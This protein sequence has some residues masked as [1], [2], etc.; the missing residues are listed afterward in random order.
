MS[1]MGDDYELTSLLKRASIMG[2]SDY[3]SIMPMTFKET[4]EAIKKLK[5]QGN[6]FTTIDREKI[7]KFAQKYFAGEDYLQQKREK[8]VHSFWTLSDVR[9]NFV[10]QTKDSLFYFIVDPVFGASYFNTTQ[11]EKILH[12]WNGAMFSGLWGDH[13]SFSAKFVD[14]HEKKNPLK[15]RA[16]SRERGIF[17]ATSMG[18]FSDVTAD[19]SYENK[20]LNFSAGKDYL[21]IGSG[22]DGQIIF[23]DKPPTIPYFK[24]SLKFTDWMELFYYFGFLKSGIVDSTSLR[25]SSINSNDKKL[26]AYSRTYDDISKYLALHAIFLKPNEDLTLT[27]GESIVFS[28]R[29]KYPFLIPIMF[30]RLADHFDSY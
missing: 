26:A 18:D 1:W 27:L 21:Q 11:N 24:Y 10:Y 23:G 14:N 17:V 28:D 4:L 29:I 6:S 8:E 9:N 15:N 13:L 19:I 2:L 5:L 25:Y 3:R 12:T 16:F 20:F 7:D 30:F 22:N